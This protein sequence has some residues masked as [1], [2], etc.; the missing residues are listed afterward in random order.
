MTWVSTIRPQKWEILTHST[1]ENICILIQMPLESV[2]M[3]LI[4]N[5]STLVTVYNPIYWVCINLFSVTLRPFRPRD[6]A[7]PGTEVQITLGFDKYVCVCVYACAKSADW[8]AIYFQRIIHYW[9]LLHVVDLSWHGLL[10]LG[11]NKKKYPVSKWPHTLM[12]YC[13][14]YLPCF[15]KKCGCHST[16]P[17]MVESWNWSR[18]TCWDCGNWSKQGIW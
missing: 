1:R 8:W 2:S 4:H 10:Q 14:N 5:M 15:R 13:Q 6:I 11:L 9:N 16:L 7:S 3:G 18:R 17:S 12:T